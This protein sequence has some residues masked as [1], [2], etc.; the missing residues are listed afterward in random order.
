VLLLQVSHLDLQLRSLNLSFEDLTARIHAQFPALHNA[1][2]NPGSMP[3][4]DNLNL[5]RNVVPLLALSAPGEGYF[6]DH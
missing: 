2:V 5:L 3:S 1:K 6:I 4:G